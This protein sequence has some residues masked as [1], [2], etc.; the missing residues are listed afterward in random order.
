MVKKRERQGERGERV[1]EGRSV[2]EEKGEEIHTITIEQKK[3]YF[4]Y[5]ILVGIVEGRLVQEG[6][7]FIVIVKN[8]LHSFSPHSFLR[9]TIA[10]NY[11]I[12]RISACH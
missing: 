10:H 12:G 3:L 7:F 8:L 4:Y 5:E 2:R 1:R 11:G 6:D 9:V